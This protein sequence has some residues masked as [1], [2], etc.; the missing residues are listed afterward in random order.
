MT[1]NEDNYL[2]DDT[3][4]RR[5][6]PVKVLLE[7]SDI[8]WIKENR[9]QLYAEAYH[10]VINLKETTWEFPKE[11]L[12]QAQDDRRI[13]DTNA[14]VVLDWYKGI[15]QTHRDV[16]ITV[17]QAFI[18]AIKPIDNFKSFDK[19]EE[20]RL[21]GILRGF[22]KLEKKREGTGANRATKWYDS[23]KIYQVSPEK[24]IQE[25]AEQQDYADFEENKTYQIKQ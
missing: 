8:K 13:E 22:L 17:R 4:N 16:G 24:M 19:L 6:L 5:W 23:K 1:T 14:D 2:K 9:E 20:M 10:R 3:G 21:G 7:E 25:L 11:L 15:Y 18:G 12:E